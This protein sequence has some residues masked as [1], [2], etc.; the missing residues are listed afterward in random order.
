MESIEYVEGVSN[1]AFL[2]I[3]KGD[4]I[5]V[6][7]KVSEDFNSSHPYTEGGDNSSYVSTEYAYRRDKLRKF[8]DAYGMQYESGLRWK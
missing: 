4:F 5:K 8:C 6:E 3:P 7:R 1:P 2:R